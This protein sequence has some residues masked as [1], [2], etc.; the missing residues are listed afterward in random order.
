MKINIKKTL[1][2]LDVGGD[3]WKN[4]LPVTLDT[5]IHS[6]TF[7]PL[8]GQNMARALQLGHSG[9]NLSHSIVCK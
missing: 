6:G 7:Q 8:P 9:V 4:I 2:K 1:F 5:A 3:R